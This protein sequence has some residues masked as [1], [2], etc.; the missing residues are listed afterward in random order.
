M[1]YFFL[2]G[3]TGF[4]ALRMAAERFAGT[5]RLVDTDAY[6]LLAEIG[7]IGDAGSGFRSFTA[8][9]LFMVV[10]FAA[11]ICKRSVKDKT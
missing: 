6:G 7:E 5:L 4:F 2:L 1:N 9:I 11:I 8:L 3:A 10:V